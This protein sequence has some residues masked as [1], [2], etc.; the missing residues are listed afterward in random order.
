LEF[1]L[2][3]WGRKLLLFGCAGYW[4]V[5][6]LV[7]LGPPVIAGWRVT[8]PDA[9]HGVINASLDGTVLRIAMSGAHTAPWSGSIG[10]WTL[11]WWIIG[12][13]FVLW[14]ALRGMQ[15]RNSPTQLRTTPHQ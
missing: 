5:L 2:D 3:K 7:L 6:L 13:P 11:V 15:Q 8:R 4:L 12:P 10:L 14:L 9:G 1:S